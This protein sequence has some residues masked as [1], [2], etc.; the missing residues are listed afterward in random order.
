MLNLLACACEQQV[1]S[2]GSTVGLLL[3]LS[4]FILLPVALVLS[5]YAL[6]NL[7]HDEYDW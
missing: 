1:E 2:S 5:A 4:M 6:E 7:T 3:V